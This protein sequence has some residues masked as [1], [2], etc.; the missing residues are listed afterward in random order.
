MIKLV[1]DRFGRDPK[2]RGV[3]IIVKSPDN[4]GKSFTIHGYS[5]MQVY[6][7]IQHLLDL[8]VEKQNQYEELSI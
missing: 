5:Y 2:E 7:L 3:M 6:K 1:K 8:H 4:K